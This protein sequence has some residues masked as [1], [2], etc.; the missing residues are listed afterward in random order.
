MGKTYTLEELQR[1]CSYWQEQLGLS[2]WRIALRIES[3][4]DLPEGVEGCNDYQLETETAAIS[5]LDPVD[6]PEGPFDQ[7]MEMRLVHELLH[8]P[9]GYVANPEK[10]S[11]E[12][13]HLE[14]AISRLAYV[15]VTLKR[16]NA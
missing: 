10:Q 12:H 1:L 9:M 2:H 6:Y 8:I 16:G 14:S 3:A 15:L 5:I 7:D 13:I 11:L 4:R